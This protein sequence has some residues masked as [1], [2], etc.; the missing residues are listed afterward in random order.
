VPR[1][2]RLRLI[3][4]EPA[5]DN[6]VMRSP[7]A[8]ALIALASCEASVEG[9]SIDAA[10]DATDA[11]IPLGAWSTPVPVA[12]TPVA[13]DDPS[14]TADLLE[15]YFNRMQ[16][17]YVV[18]RPSLAMPWGT[19]VLVAELSSPENDT[20]PEVSHDGLV[21][22]LASNRPGG[23]GGFDIWCATRA[24]RD[25]AWGAPVLVPELNSAA[26]E[27]SSATTDNLTMVLDSS[28]ATSPDIYLS[29]RA[30][31]LEPWGAPM[32]LAPPSGA[33]ND[34]NPA[35]SADRLELYFDSD[36]TGDAELHI[37]AR[38]DVGA[39]FAAAELIT[40]LASPGLDNDAWISPD[41]RTLLF[42]SDRDGT[43]RLWQSTR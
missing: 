13:D 16:D 11:P 39:T 8:A 36:R 2:R 28:R 3:P 32:L 33:T 37:S 42:T 6:S 19:P 43:V 35:L 20:T 27:T 34:T 41:R 40:E 12:I 9:V 7:A 26:T 10:P 21:I 38:P 18:T 22:Y 4:G 24:D 5:V 29:T 31:P 17:I 23:L 15:L 30:T 1:Q 25:A 14:A